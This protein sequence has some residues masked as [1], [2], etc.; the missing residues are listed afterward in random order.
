MH[1]LAFCPLALQI[2]LLLL[3]ML[4]LVEKLSNENTHPPFPNPRL[5]SLVQ[6]VFRGRTCECEF[7]RGQSGPPLLVVCFML[8]TVACVDASV[9]PV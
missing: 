8:K 1:V 6:T 5:S 7:S 4:Y 9:L 2:L 3:V